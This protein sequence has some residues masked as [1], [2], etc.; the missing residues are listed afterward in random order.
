ML[1]KKVLL[2]GSTG[3][4]GSMI[5]KRLMG[6]VELFEICRS[7]Q[8]FSDTGQVIESSLE[9]FVRVQD[10]FRKVRPDIVIHCAAQI[11][12]SKNPDS[13][14]LANINAKVDDAVISAIE[15]IGGSLIYMSSTIVY[16]NPEFT[17]DIDENFPVK[18]DTYYAAQKIQ[19]EQR[20]MDNLSNALVLRLNAPYG[21]NMRVD[22][23]LSLFLKKA[24][25]NDPIRF[26]GTG[27]RMQDFT[28]TKDIAELLFSIINSGGVRSGVYNISAGQPI[29]MLD[30]AKKIIEMT[31]SQSKIA[32]S[33]ILD[34]QENVK[35]SFSIEKAQRLLNWNPRVAL[36]VG[37]QELMLNL[38]EN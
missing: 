14:D 7:S 28:N 30:L 31:K 21:I 36:E 2:T 1:K 11:P 37:I 15:W 35:A 16:G 33:G 32:E 17:F 26:H 12:T 18:A 38:R 19:A 22:T 9:D 20:I 10:I 24:L 6:A 29:S 27:Q 8:T 23:V 25:V 34:E 4:V 3:L 5:R 13:A